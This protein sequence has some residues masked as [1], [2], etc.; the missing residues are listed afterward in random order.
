MTG[1]CHCLGCPEPIEETW[2]DG[3]YGDELAVVC[4][5]CAGRFPCEHEHLVY[6]CRNCGYL[7]PGIA[8][9]GWCCD[10]LYCNEGVAEAAH[11]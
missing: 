6:E 3:S 9:N 1:R 11:D 10:I 5:G 4:A 2:E 7:D 8:P